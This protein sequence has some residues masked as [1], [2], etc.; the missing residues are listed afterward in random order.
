MSISSI[1]LVDI[2]NTSALTALECGGRFFGVKRMSTCVSSCR[3]VRAFLRPYG[4]KE[5]SGAIVSSVVPEFDLIWRSELKRIAGGKI[6]FVSHK[7]NLGVKISY[8][9]P[10]RIGS[11]RLANAVGASEKYGT[12]VVVADFGTALTFDFVSVERAYLG[13]IIL[14]GPSVFAQC[15]AGRTA[16]LPLLKE[17][18]IRKI[19]QPK[20][21]RTPRARSALI[22]KCTEE[23]MLIGVRLGYLGMV[24][25]VFDEIV[26]APFARKAKIC[27]TGGY[28]EMIMKAAG[29]SIPCDP[30][31]TLRGISRIWSLNRPG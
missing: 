13:G 11:D 30:L 25:K 3:Q 4:R 9:N 6:M 17:N 24:K 26:R 2:G 5:I 10:A 23:A 19:F 1:M 20:P 18:E 14:P 31:L 21:N 29:L 27:A 12:P 8:P 22:G 15:L 7:L 28:A 16:L